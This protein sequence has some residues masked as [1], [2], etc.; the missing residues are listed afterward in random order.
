MNDAGEGKLKSVRRGAAPV[1][2]QRTDRRVEAA[3]TKH[4]RTPEAILP[5]L[6]TVQAA[7]QGHLAADI[8]GATADTLR[9]SDAQVYGVASFYSLLSIRP[10]GEKQIGI[11]DGPVCVLQGAERVRPVIEAAGSKD[12]WSIQRCSCLGLCDRA[13]AALVGIEPCGPI[14]AARVGDM[15]A[16]WCG[17]MPSYAKPRPGEVRV[18][19]ARLG[20]I[21]PDSISSAR[22]TGAYQ[23]LGT[24]LQ[25]HPS[26]VLD[27][28][29]RAGLRG[30][31]GA[32]FPAGRKWRMVREVQR[33]PRYI[34]CNA[35]ESEPGAFKDRVLIDGDPHLLLEG[36]ALA[37]YAVGASAGVIYVRGEYE[38]IARQLE[39]AIVEAEER[40]WLGENIHGRGFSFRLHVHRGAGA[41][42]C[43]EETALLNSLEGRRGEPRVRPPY[44][45]TH[46]YH[47]HP[48]VVNNVETLCHVP[49]IVSRGPDW[50]RSLGT[51]G[52]PGTKMFTVTGCVNKPGAFE[53]PLGITLRQ[54]I[55]QFGGGLI[56]GSGFK[57]ALTGGAAGSF[58]PASMLDIPIDFDSWKN[59]LML[60][61]GPIII[62]DESVSI[63][64]V[65]SSV[66]HFFEMESCGKCT[67]CREGTREVRRLC[68]RLAN[69]RA[70]H[71]DLSELK[72]L[73]HQM[74]LTSL[75]G[76]G[77]S[78]ALPI[79]S[80]LRYFEAEF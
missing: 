55:E 79:E 10:R 78:V 63:P 64:Q 56:A 45:T 49:A 20:Q 77:Q 9:V 65:L 52:S 23:V 39:H 58:V 54:M 30:C 38:W 37:A 4:G 44:P 16:G 61:S 41:Y 67:P 68:E 11:C 12:D 31:G 15:L 25:S 8:L 42:I 50:F 14:T 80:A 40:G 1:Q 72:R 18:L 47:G 28:I 29:E 34:V 3:A 35:D 57:A 19:M 59:G 62:L 17:A 26:A 5:V 69:L 6:R 60:G 2:A 33:T 71:S 7:S 13:P 46:G 22:A 76:L 73:A 53:A 21:D 70:N 66:L 75:C 74:N 51:P 27:A 43:G 36:M 48:T 32:G 24:A